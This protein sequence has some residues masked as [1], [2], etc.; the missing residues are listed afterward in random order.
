[1]SDRLKLQKFLKELNDGRDRKNSILKDEMSSPHRDLVRSVSVP[2]DWEVQTTKIQLTKGLANLD[3]EKK[4]LEK[5]RRSFQRNVKSFEER[6]SSIGDDDFLTRMESSAR[7]GTMM[8][9]RGNKLVEDQED[10]AKAVEKL[11]L[12]KWEQ[13]RTSLNQEQALFA[14]EKDLEQRERKLY[15]KEAAIREAKLAEKEE[16]WKK[17]ELTKEMERSDLKEVRFQQNEKSS[18]LSFREKLLATGEEKLKKANLE[19]EK[20]KALVRKDKDLCAKRNEM[21]RKEDL[22]LSKREQVMVRR[23]EVFF[24]RELE[25]KKEKENM[26]KEKSED[27]AFSRTLAKAKEEQVSKKLKL[28]KREERTREDLK[29]REEKLRMDVRKFD[30]REK[31]QK[32][33]TKEISIL[34]QPSICGSSDCSRFWNRTLESSK[35]SGALYNSTMS[36]GPNSLIRSQSSGF[37]EPKAPNAEVMV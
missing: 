36:N 2:N 12:Q 8:T 16:E 9:T 32:V 11:N 25:M 6:I 7:V 21:A 33:L 5:F 34:R 1:M 30:K 18:E 20:E 14:R 23:E 37:F 3:L 27:M 17:F 19:L 26:K 10:I 28:K 29:V 15:K 35:S 22:S 13:R 31:Q 24:Q 4:H